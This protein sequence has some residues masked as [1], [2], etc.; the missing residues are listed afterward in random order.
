MAR[1]TKLTDELCEKL[2]KEIREGTPEGTA[3]QL[4]GISKRTLINWKNRAKESKRKTR[5]TDFLHRLDEAKAFGAKLHLKAIMNSKD[6]KAH[7]YLLSL[8]D[9]DYQDSEKIK[10]EHSGQIDNGMVV[11]E[12]KDLFKEAEKGND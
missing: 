3:A 10:L 7:R 8:L 6:W 12:T 11:E 2:F 4:V 5:Y 1:P 9:E